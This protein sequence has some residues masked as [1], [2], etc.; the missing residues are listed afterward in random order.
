MSIRELLWTLRKHL[1][2]R[3]YP[4]AM[5]DWPLRL[6]E[7]HDGTRLRDIL[8]RCEAAAAKSQ[9][10]WG[11]TVEFGETVQE[12]FLGRG[13]L[14]IV[15]LLDRWRWWPQDLAGLRIA[16]VGC[17][18]GGHSAIM[19]HRGAE[20]VYAVDELPE[21]LAQC[22][23]LCAA[24]GLE[25]VTRLQS[26]VYALDQR[27]DTCS[28]DLI[29]LSGVLYHLSDMLVGLLMMR[30]L[31]KPGA[32][33]ILESNGV[34]DMKRSYAN[35]GR[36][37]GGMWWQPSGR[38][39]LD[40]LEFMGFRDAEVRFYKPDRCLARAVRDESAEIPFKRGMN[41]PFTDLV[42]AERRTMNERVMAPVR[43]RL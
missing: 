3:H 31:L 7:D 12:G 43:P 2:K 16:D 18:T 10:G 1:A 11:Q 36:Y 25:Q 23:A 9:Y 40:M 19:A 34:E 26:S 5:A 15:G 4:R 13:Y 8:S 30:K 28:L 6:P 27:I 22:E 41:W 20:R 32:A 37:Y 35:F 24:Y 42:D 29:M 21:H 17:F 14:E 38:C 39:I 33:L